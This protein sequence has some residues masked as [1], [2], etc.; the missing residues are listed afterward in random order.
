MWDEARHLAGSCLG[1]PGGPAGAAAL[2]AADA[3]VRAR[4]GFGLREASALRQVRSARVPML[5]IHGT[6]D[7]FVPF[8]MLDELYE[9]CASPEKECLAVEG[10]GHAGSVLADP[11]RYWGAVDAFIARHLG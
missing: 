7:D 8:R 11:A 10:A 6:A 2:A 9:A 4:A 3:V 1:L 5:L